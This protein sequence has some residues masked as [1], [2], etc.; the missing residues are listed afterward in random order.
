[1][2]VF[3]A[4]YDMNTFSLAEC[5]FYPRF[6]CLQQKQDKRKKEKRSQCQIKELR[7]EHGEVTHSK[8]SLTLVPQE[9]RVPLCCMANR[10][11]KIG[12]W[13]KCLKNTCKNIS[14]LFKNGNHSTVEWHT[15]ADAAHTQRHVVPDPLFKHWHSERNV[16][17]YS[18]ARSQ[19]RWDE[20]L[21]SRKGMI[22]AL[23]R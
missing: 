23:K 4:H 2:G 16:L 18:V 13:N 14:T 8:N 12:P 9:L 10:A 3:G 6:L 15:Y 11:Y 19:T 1:M 5:S 17:C 20:E 21:G 22:N 7:I